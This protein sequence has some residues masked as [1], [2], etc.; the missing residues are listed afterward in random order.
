METGL[1]FSRRD[2]PTLGR[3]IWTLNWQCMN[4]A[5]SG[6]YSHFPKNSANEGVDRMIPFHELAK[7]E[8]SC[9][10]EPQLQWPG[11][12]WTDPCFQLTWFIKEFFFFGRPIHDTGQFNTFSNHTSMTWPIKYLVGSNTLS[13]RS[14]QPGKYKTFFWPTNTL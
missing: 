3:K 1:S 7:V 10:T 2:W 14:I 4:H 9:R 6:S 11:Q 5:K 12:L 13:V 8:G